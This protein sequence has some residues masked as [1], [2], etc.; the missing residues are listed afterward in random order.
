[1]RI[2]TKEYGF[3]PVVPFRY[4]H[5]EQ[6]IGLCARV[7]VLVYSCKITINHVSQTQ[8][9]LINGTLHCYKFRLLRNHHR[10]VRTK[11]LKHQF[12]KVIRKKT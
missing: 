12:F 4:L 10:A 3:G 7:Y 9:S 6:Q 5:A 1:M 8:H 11:H 2:A